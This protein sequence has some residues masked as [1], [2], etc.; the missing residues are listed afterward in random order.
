MTGSGCWNDYR[1]IGRGQSRTTASGARN[2]QHSEEG[3]EVSLTEGPATES[4]AVVLAVTSGKGGVGKTS[5]SVNMAVE[6]AKSDYRTLVFDCDLGLANTQVSGAGLEHLKGLMYFG[7]LYLDGTNLTDAGLENLKGL[8]Y[9]Y[10]LHLDGTKVTDA[11]LEHLKG[12]TEL[13]YLYL[14]DT[15]VNNAGVKKLQQALPNCE[16][17]H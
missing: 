8:R 4:G 14:K 12:L 16:I 5:V 7:F 6:F 15:R 3:R 17:D 9:L 1:G 13:Q 11:G 2:E 10:S